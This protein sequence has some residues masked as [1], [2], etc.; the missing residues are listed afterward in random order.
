MENKVVIQQ[1]ARATNTRY[2][3]TENIPLTIVIFIS[4]TTPSSH[5]HR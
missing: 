4:H 5:K 2:D 1:S 3:K